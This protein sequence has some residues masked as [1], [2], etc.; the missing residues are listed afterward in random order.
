MSIIQHLAAPAQA[1][2]PEL[3]NL[4]FGDQRIGVHGP[5]RAL[6]ADPRMRRRP[7]A[8]VTDQVAESYARLRLVNQAIDDPLAFAA[9]PYRLTAL[10]EWIAPLDGALAVIASIHYNLFLGSLIDHDQ[11][12]KRPLGGLAAMEQLGTFLCTELGHGNDAANLETTATYHR[13]SDTFTLHT[14]LAAAQK[15]MPNTG[16]AGGPKSAVVA[17][18][19][20]VDGHDVGVFLFLT[21]LSNEAGPL[22]GVTV[23]PLP[24]RTGS[25]IDHCLTAFDQVPLPREAL[26]TGTH[27]Q[28][29]AQ[30]AFSSALGSRRKRFLAAIGR[31][32]LG[33]LCMSA[34]AI[35]AAR[36]AVAIAVRYGH[37][38]TVSGARR[39]QTVPVFAH[40]THHQPLLSALATTYAMTALHREAVTRW[41]ERQCADPADTA[42]AERQVAI[43]KG[44]ITWQTRAVLTECRE[45]CG[46]QGLFAHNGIAQLV[47][48][49]EGAITA[50]GD[51]LA[52]WAKAGAEL[53][54]SPDEPEPPAT[55]PATI[56]D[57]AR[58]TALQA[59]LH[60]AEQLHLDHARTRLRQAPAGDQLRRWNA[61]APF[62]LAGVT[63]RAERQ[64]AAAL[65]ALA[66]RAHDP[67][68]RT[69]LLELH[70]LFAL[71]RLIGASGQLLSHGH[72]T[73]EQA[74]ALPE[75]VSSTLDQL[76]GR[77]L[78][79]V[80]AFDLPEEAVSTH[81]I[82]TAHY[83]D[84]YDDPKGA[85]HRPHRDIPHPT[86]PHDLTPL[87]SAHEGP[88][89]K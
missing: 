60:T 55:A 34:C 12:P 20:L 50:E 74:H 47:L 2:L 45:R 87:M 48:D 51:N 38:R 22:P 69:V 65:L 68:T 58:P 18:R 1:P 29:D 52:L 88:Y 25:P 6:S 37:H 24:E 7:A 36:T 35:G 15:F 10:H 66:D 70:R 13:D 80:D 79:L 26:L 17:A 76:A 42:A 57:L 54:F 33:K 23:R 49:V 11:H 83:Q 9:D 89:A 44:W 39:G 53:L 81:P 32:T 30:G 40:R 85:W 67:Q 46:A 86:P 73:V 28:L 82:A 3:G 43:A 31:V 72:L 5:W 8:N 21:P 62:A 41:A 16:P 77:A 63:A 64:A 75:L 59:L 71:Q 14:P 78:A 61:A 56:S 4:L 27:G 84:A 19:L